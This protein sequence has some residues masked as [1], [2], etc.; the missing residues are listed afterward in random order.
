M[1]WLI[2]FVPL[3]AVVAK[4]A[5]DQ[6]LLVFFT[7]ALAIVPLVEWIARATEDLARRTNDQLG[8]LL[9]A[10]FGNAAELI[11]GLSAL[12]VGLD[13]VVKASLVGSIVGNNLLCLGTAMLVGGLRCPNQRFNAEGARIEASMLALAV[14]AMVLPAAY[15][16]LPGDGEP[17]HLAELSVG[18]AIVLLVVYSLNLLFTLKTHP[19]L[20]LVARPKA[21][22]EPEC[23][24]PR[25]QW[26]K[27]HAAMILALATAGAV[28]MSEILVSVVEPAAQRM[29][30]STGFISLFLVGILGNI[31]EQATAIRAALAGRMD[32]A[33]SIAM[34]S[35]VQI[36]LVVIPTVV[37]MSWLISPTPMDLAF[38]P[39][40]VLTL[41]LT[42]YITS[43]VAN[44]G[45][46]YWLKGAQL[47]AVYL[48]LGF[49]LYFVPGMTR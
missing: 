6:P 33:F 30:M 10:T 4:L 22:G 1:A 5:P 37:L 48:I 25:A 41:F 28:W 24:R 29:G 3:A 35:S 11:I 44:D 16:L 8:G 49:T 15:R 40:L 23:D 42:V 34:G 2:L 38:S 27:G 7:A 13:E 12:R 31:A 39:K 45:H 46:S 14:I 18:I 43:Q 36:S 9:N 47:L 19:N 20:F 21:A 17:P 26:S 32:L